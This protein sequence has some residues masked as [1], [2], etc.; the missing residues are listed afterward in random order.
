MIQMVDD[1]RMLELMLGGDQ[2][3]FVRM[4]TRYQ[5]VLVRVARICGEDTTSSESKRSRPDPCG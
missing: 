1:A 2:A 4:V 3:A 5:G